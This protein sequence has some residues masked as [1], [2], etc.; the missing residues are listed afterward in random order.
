MARRGRRPVPAKAVPAGGERIAKSYL[1]ALLAAFGAA[2]WGVI[3]WQLAALLPVCGLD[4]SGTCASLWGG[5]ATVLGYLGILAAAGAVLGLG[6]SFWIGFA[7]GLL[8][9]T[10][11]VIE[12]DLPGLLALAVLFP[13]VAAVA[14]DPARAGALRGRRDLAV[15]LL[16]LVVLLEFALWVF[17]LLR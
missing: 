1:A 10:Q 7:S 17:L 2:L 15:L 11:L 9:V 12:L 5:L 16:G 13:A 6:R 3:A 4:P 14:S 8:L